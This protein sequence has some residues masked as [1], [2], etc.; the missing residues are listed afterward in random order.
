MTIPNRIS[1][2]NLFVD[3]V[4]TSKAFYA[5][6]FGITPVNEDEVSVAFKFGDVIINLLHVG[7]AA[8]IVEPDRVGARS[9]GAR[10]QLTVWLDDVD[11]IAAELAR[12]GIAF[13]GPIDRSW[14]LRT[15]NFVDPSGH[16]WE[17][18]QRIAS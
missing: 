7:S 18:G 1:A 5:N 6:V 16:S 12:R 8:E 10:F 4:A 14:G 11:A 2:I 9:D 3:D 13:N 17:V 15:I